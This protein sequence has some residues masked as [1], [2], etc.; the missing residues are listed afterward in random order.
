MPLVTLVGAPGAGKK[1]LAQMAA[2]AVADHF[3]DGVWFVDLTAARD[4]V[5][6]GEAIAAALGI[7][8]ATGGQIGETLER[9]LRAQRSLLILDNFEQVLPAAASVNELLRG[10]PRLKILATSRAPL[11]LASDAARAL[12]ELRQLPVVACDDATTHA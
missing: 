2:E 6:V 12:L 4:P 1:R 10:C 9:V 3:S 11:R 5:Q 8:D 7:T